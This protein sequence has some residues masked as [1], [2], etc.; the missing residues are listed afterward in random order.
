VHF[1]GE[2]MQS[3]KALRKISLILSFILVMFGCATSKLDPGKNQA[4]SAEFGFITEPVADG[5]LLTFSNIPSDA[6]RLFIH[7]SYWD[8]EDYDDPRN[9]VSSVADIRDISLQ[10]NKSHSIQLDRV[11]ETGKVIVPILQIGQN[12]RIIATV[13]NKQE[14]E[15]LMSDIYF[16]KSG[17]DT[18][19][20]AENGIYFDDAYIK[21][22]MNDSNTAVT[23]FSEP[24]FS[25]EVIFYPLKYNFGITIIVPEG[26]ISTWSSHIPDGLS[27]DGLSWTFEPQ[28]TE[29]FKDIEWIKNGVSYTA[30]ATAEVNIIHDDISWTIEIASSPIFTYSL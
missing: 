19:I 2:I 10:A 29:G 20:I 22:E 3:F 15:S 28:M 6:V 5:I 17:V 9:I 8:N 12:Y 26:S 21:L 23:L 16:W 13:Y 18:E 14:H 30:W 24:I 27:T 7:A 1:G 25:S 4:A 11:K